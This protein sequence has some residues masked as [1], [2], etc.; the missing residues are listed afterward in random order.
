MK[1]DG[2]SFQPAGVE[3]DGSALQIHLKMCFEVSFYAF[4]ELLIRCDLGFFLILP[5]NS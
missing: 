2:L 4:Y 3:K 5:Y 1:E